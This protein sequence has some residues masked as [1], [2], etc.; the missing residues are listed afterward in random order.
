MVWLA[1]L[2]R[3]TI[4]EQVKHQTKCSICRQCP[5]KGFRYRSLKQF[6][7]DICQTCF[8]TGRA[9]KGNKLHY[10][11]MEYYTPTTS[12]ENMRD[13]ATTLKNKFR[14]KHYFS[15][16]PQ[17]GY[18]PVQSVLEADYNETLAEM[19]SQNCSFFNDSLSPDDSIDEDQYLL[20]H[21]S[22][23]TDREPG[24]GQQASC[25]MATES[26]GKLEKILAHLE[27]EN[28]ILQGELRRLKWQ[29][30]E[31]AE[32]P[33]LAEG[34]AEGAQDHRNEELLAEARIL[35][36]HKS[37]LETRMQILEDH[38]K[39]LES[40]LQRLRELLLQPP[41]ESDG[42]GSAGSS[43]ASSPLQS[44]SSHPQEKEQTTPNTEAEDGVNSKSQDV[45]LCLE[46]IMKK[47][48]H[49]FPSMQSSDVT[50]NTLLAS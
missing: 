23:I 26:K 38:N 16:H 17:R 50:A 34:T 15:K 8:L 31:A 13:F 47:L 37:R 30:E 20:Q 35:R 5:I 9:S 36:Q 40:Q 43:L 49:A 2:H 6:N 18:L 39:Q 4:A 29:H 7:V 48:R 25:N 45:S 46:D 3:V 11:I 33:A 27:D 44:E 41:T 12:S 14:S 1:V 32:A 19:E 42:N 28:R 22:P 10:P 21:S 24:F